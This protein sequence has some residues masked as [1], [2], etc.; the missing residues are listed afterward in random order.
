VTTEPPVTTTFHLVRHASHDRL[1]HMMC[2]RMPGVT[3]SAQGLAETKALAERLAREPVQAVV[4]SPLERAQQTAKPIADRHGLAV[5]KVDQLNEIDIGAWSGRTFP[6]LEADPV[7]AAWNQARFVT[8]PP[9]G[10]TM[11]DVQARSVSALDRLRE[12]YREAQLVL[13][14]HADVIKAVIAHY[15]GL[16]LDLIQRF[17]VNPASITTLVVGSWGAKLLRLNEAAS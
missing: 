16:A 13:V 14:S 12:R 3:L 11:L 1:G 5:E 9:G 7:W 15:L 17:E 8:R 4:S 2:G 10:E 6:E